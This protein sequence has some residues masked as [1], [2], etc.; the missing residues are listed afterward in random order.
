MMAAG[1]SS[2]RAAWDDPP[3]AFANNTRG[4]FNLLEAL[5]RSAPGAHLTM[6]SSASV[7]GPPQSLPLTEDSATEPSSPYGASKLAAE[8]LCRQHARQHGTGV[9]VL[10]LF[11]QIGPGQGTGQAPSEFARQIAVAEKRGERGLM[12]TVGNPDSERDFTDVREAAGGIAGVVAGRLEGTFNLCSG[13]AT[14]I[15]SI[16][17]GLNLSTR[18]EVGMLVDPE[19]AHPADV[20]SLYG[21]NGKLNGSSGWVPEMSLDRSLEDLLEDWRCRV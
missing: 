19:R 8:M 11:N 1:L 15:G 5:G 2:V 4:V 3:A 10:R 16:V 12:I 13:E 9:A 14:T 20:T 6:L 17:H 18:V 21:S 7:Y